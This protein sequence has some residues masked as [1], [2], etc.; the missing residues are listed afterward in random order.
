MLIKK[1]IT[2]TAAVLALL[3]IGALGIGKAFA[4]ESVAKP[5]LSDHDVAELIQ[6]MDTDKNGKVSKQE[7]MDFMS[8]EFDRLDK[9]K[10]GD[11]DPKELGNSY[12]R[13]SLRFGDMGK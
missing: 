4:G 3:A 9:D 13:P 8:K 1:S 11:L 10:S 7:F 2:G 12:L 6:M 5:M